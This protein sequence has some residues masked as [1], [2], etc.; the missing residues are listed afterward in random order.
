[1]LSARPKITAF[2]GVALLSTEVANVLSR[3]RTT[4]ML[5]IDLPA[6]S[7]PYYLVRRRDRTLSPIAE[8]FWQGMQT[9]AGAI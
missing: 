4:T 9:R 7:E 5:P 2:T 6:R 8:R 1:M 3:T